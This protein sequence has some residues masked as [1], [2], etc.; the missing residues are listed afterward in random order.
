MKSWFENFWYYYKWHFI[1]IVL[2]A[3]IL[4]VTTAQCISSEKYDYKIVVALED[5]VLS[6]KQI[7]IIE[8]G[9]AEYG[10]D[11]NGDGKVTVSAMNC[12]YNK[13]DNTNYNYTISMQ[14][15]L[16]INAM[17]N[18]EALLYITNTETFKY[19]DEIKKDEGG[20]FVNCNLPDK[21]GKALNLTNFK[22]FKELQN[23][24]LPVKDLYVCKRVI[25][26]TL[27]EKAKNIEKTEKD[28][29]FLLKSLANSAK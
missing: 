19:I 4:T 10:K 12:T 5:C 1:A 22:F 29:D 9:I 6:E 7:K 24:A 25:K 26:G 21:N 3:V 8:K 13:S 11:L 28:N 18:E 17:G 15:K 16:Q 2:A 23:F 20:F 14:Q 27:L